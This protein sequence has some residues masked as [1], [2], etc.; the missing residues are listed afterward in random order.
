MRFGT[1]EILFFGLMVALLG[2]FYF[3][4]LTKIDA[5]KKE[6]AEDTGKKAK[7]VADVEQSTRGIE[8]L[9]RKIGELQEAI[10]FFESKLPQEKEM[11][12]I[13]TEVSQLADANSLSTRTVKTLKSERSAGY[14]EQPIEM[15]LSGDFNAFYLYLQQLEKLPRLTRVT[16]MSLNKINER[17]GE[18]DAKLTL[19]IFFEP[20]S[21]AASASA[22]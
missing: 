20:D 8:D 12:K 2:G 21:A 6:L 22:R 9:G 3:G 15:T 4:M 1:R 16:S 19:S 13:L 17:D 14:S 7:M 18:M 5:R 11:D 10:K